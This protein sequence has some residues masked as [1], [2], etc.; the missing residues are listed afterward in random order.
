MMGDMLWFTRSAA[1]VIGVLV[2]AL[3]PT[4]AW[5]GE[6]G[7]AAALTMAD[8]AARAPRL[9]RVGLLGTLCCLVVVALV[10]LALVLAGRSRRRR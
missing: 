2:A 7:A 8:E 9:G 5:A 6:G 10:V 3:T 4:R 1:P